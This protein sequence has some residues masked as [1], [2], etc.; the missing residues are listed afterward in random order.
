MR[1]VGHSFLSFGINL[2]RQTKNKTVKNK[3]VKN[4]AVENMTDLQFK[5]LLEMVVLILK[6]SDTLEDAIQKSLRI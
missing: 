4:K 2:S 5:K 6:S 3:A 1:T